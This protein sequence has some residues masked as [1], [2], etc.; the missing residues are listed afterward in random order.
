MAVEP[1]ICTETFDHW[2]CSKTANSETENVFG[3]KR[4]TD[5]V[6]ACVSR[7]IVTLVG[8]C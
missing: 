1:E 8:R 6:S 4:E 7:S 3:R 5:V 2:N